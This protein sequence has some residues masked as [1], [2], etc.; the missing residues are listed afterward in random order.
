MSTKS[1][2][3]ITTNSRTMI[4]AL[5]S[6]TDQVSKRGADAAF[7][8]Q[9]DSDLLK[10]I[11]LDNQVSELKA[12]VKLKT[13]ELDTAE[14]T[15]KANYSEARKIVKISVDQAGWKAFGIDDSK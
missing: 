4:S 8:A 1:F 5:V 12:Q 6:H 2:A 15:L 7:I 14:S 13:A 9:L 3:E 11:N 10:A